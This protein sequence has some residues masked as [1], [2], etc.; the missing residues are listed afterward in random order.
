MMDAFKVH[1][2]S[3][4][5]PD[6]CFIKVNLKK[7]TE[8]R[9]KTLKKLYPK[10]IIITDYSELPELVFLDFYKKIEV[11]RKEK[12]GMELKD[13]QK[14]LNIIPNFKFTTMKTEKLKIGAT[15]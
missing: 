1:V 7:A 12:N 14:K 10:A 6:E 8:K 9:I 15:L 2:H 11:T 4:L 5:G 13:Y 3:L